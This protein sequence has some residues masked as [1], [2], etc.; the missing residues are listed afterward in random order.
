MKAM[1]KPFT[2]AELRAM[3]ENDGSVTGVISVPWDETGD[4]DALNDQASEALT[5]SEA[6]L[7]DIGY[8]LVGADLENQEVLLEVTGTVENW[9][10]DQDADEEGGSA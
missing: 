1:V 9:L 6:A 10:A 3:Q 2:L 8:K 4:I 5:G 7:E